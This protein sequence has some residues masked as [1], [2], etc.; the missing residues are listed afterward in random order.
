MTLGGWI[1]LATSIAVV[2][3]LTA[4]C[5]WRVLT[6]PPAAPEDAHERESES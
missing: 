1:V 3:T 5:F 2:T 6:A 4:F